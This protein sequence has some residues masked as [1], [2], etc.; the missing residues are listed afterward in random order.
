[1]E[2]A[3]VLCGDIDISVNLGNVF[4][5]LEIRDNS[6]SLIGNM[7]TFHLLLDQA[8]KKQ[9]IFEMRL[10]KLRNE[11]IGLNF[12]KLSFTFGGEEVSQ[13]GTLH[14]FSS[15]FLANGRLPDDFW[16]RI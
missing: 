8:D 6:V 4:S 5:Y 11:F 12:P 15:Y 14:Y 13:T 3:L 7:D 1:M 2:V 10:F 16:P 9:L